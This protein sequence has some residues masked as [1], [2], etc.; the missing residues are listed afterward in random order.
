MSKRTGISQQLW[1]AFLIQAALISLVA[2]LSIYAARFVVGDI[3]IKRALQEEANHFWQL[4]RQEESIHRPN[5]YNLRGYLSGVDALPDYLNNLQP[6]FHELKTG[7]DAISIVYITDNDDK[8]LYLVFDNR[9]V[10]NLALLFGMLPLTVI[11]IVIYLSSWIAYRFSSRAVSPVIKL[12]RELET[13]DPASEAFSDKLKDSLSKN[14]SREVA[15]LSEAL[16]GL[17]GRI[18]S[19]LERERN[20]TRDA[21]HELRSPITVIKMASELLLNDEALNDRARKQ[22][23]RIKRNADDMEELIETL[24]LLARESDQALSADSVSINDIVTEEIER[25]EN[26]LEDK[27]VTINF[28]PRNQLVVVASDKVVSVM[29]GNIIRNAFSY[30]DEGEVRIT[31]KGTELVIEDSGIGIP[32][33]EVPDLFRPFQ[34]GKHK[35]RGGYGVGLTIVKMLSDRFNWPIN[36]ESELNKGTR[37]TI[38]FPR[39]KV[40]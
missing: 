2:I 12:A 27:H 19:F 7:G 38:S 6:G 24:L 35:Q 1:Q 39:G 4:Y 11:L 21:S 25:A 34:R 9:Q 3:L 30:T 37:V 20:F 15:T 26:L 16:Y 10:G 40:V 17:S 32:D 23:E 36:I 8:L 13:L 28:Q 22:A 18:A 31:V 5:T 14:T 33:N 29:I